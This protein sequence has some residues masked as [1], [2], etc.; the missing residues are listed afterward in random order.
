MS[1]AF[2]IIPP[3]YKKTGA[4]MTLP[5]A[6]YGVFRLRHGTIFNGAGWP[7]P[8]RNNKTAVSVIK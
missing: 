5:G 4:V 3:K 8:A 6:A 7:G 1:P 2:L